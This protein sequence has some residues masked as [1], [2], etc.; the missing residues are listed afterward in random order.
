MARALVVMALINSAAAEKIS[1]EIL[2]SYDGK[3]LAI[4]IMDSKGN[5]LASK[6]TDSF[7]KAFGVY[8]DGPK[9]GGTLAIAALSIANEVRGVTGEAR[10]ITTTYEKCKMM[11]ISI[12]SYEILAGFVLHRRVVLDE[13]RIANYIEGLVAENTTAASTEEDDDTSG[14]AANDTTTRDATT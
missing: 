12:P 11:L 6:S 7:K 9:Y 1:D 3:I 5:F 8:Q 13:D 14:N 2:S 4:S 10:A